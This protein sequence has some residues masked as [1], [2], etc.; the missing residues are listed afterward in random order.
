MKRIVVFLLVLIMCLSLC[1]CGSKVAENPY[2]KYEELFVYL[3]TNDYD[4][5]NA[6][7]QNFF[8]KNVSQPATE[9]IEEMPVETEHVETEPDENKLQYRTIEITLENWQDYFEL[10]TITVTHKNGFNE[11][12]YFFP[13]LKF[14]VREEWAD[15]MSDMHVVFEYRC[16]DS[17][18]CWFSYNMDTEELI[19]GEKTDHY[20]SD[21]WGAIRTLEKDDIEYGT[22]LYGNSKRETVTLDGNIAKIV[23]DMY[24][25]VEILRIEGTITVAE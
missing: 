25:T 8:G 22:W 20:V 9:P 10:K 3:E 13:Q 15:A 5:A 12:D 1:A 23:A 7:I 14:L 4:S 18:A 6:Y 2:A 21:P 11:I 24:S 17:Y 16:T 19:E